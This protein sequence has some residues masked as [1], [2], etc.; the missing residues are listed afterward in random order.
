[1]LKEWILLGECLP[2][3]GY[4]SERIVYYL[5]RDLALYRTKS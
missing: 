4:S 3:I 2:C 1:M 5:A